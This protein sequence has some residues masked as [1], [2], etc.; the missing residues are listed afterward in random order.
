MCNT[1]WKNNRHFTWLHLDIYYNVA[2]NSSYNE[3][4][5]GQNC[6]GNQNTRFISKKLFLNIWSFMRK[7]GKIC[8][9][10]MPTRCNRWFLLPILLLAQHVSDTIM[11]IIRSSRVLY[12]W[13]LSVV[14]GALVFK[15]SVR[16]GAEGYVSGLWAAAA[17]CWASNKICNKNHLLPLV[18]ILF[19]HIFPHFLING[20]IFRN[21]FF[22]YKTCVLIPRT[23]LSETFLI[24]RRIQRYI[25][26]NVQM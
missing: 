25:I 1:Q 3:K 11:H 13:L 18:G 2:L 6:T 10:K 4:C 17:A 26:I 23:I 19:P 8:G 9:N 14:F 24:I 15:W 7:C 16:C 5:F 20:Q 21:K 12:K 22:G